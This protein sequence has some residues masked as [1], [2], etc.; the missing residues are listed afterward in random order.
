MRGLPRRTTRRRPPRLTLA[1][2]I[3]RRVPATLAT[4][5]VEDWRDRASCRGHDPE[6]WF[7]DTKDLASQR[8]LSVDREGYDRAM[9]GLH[10][11]HRE[12][13]VKAFALS[14][15]GMARIDV[16]VPM[17]LPLGPIV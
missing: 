1:R 16:G 9:A 14:A 12:P 15:R 3:A 11:H 17:C 2:P 8:G 7:A 13:S 6:L 5:V 10:F 4:E